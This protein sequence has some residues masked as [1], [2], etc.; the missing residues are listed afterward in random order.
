MKT[1]KQVRDTQT[2]RSGTGNRVSYME[3]TPRQEGDTSLRLARLVLGE[4]LK[5]V[6]LILEVSDVSI[7][8][9]V[10]C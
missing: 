7:A 5:L 6:V 4:E 8:D 1:N 3:A 10:T 9:R 2:S